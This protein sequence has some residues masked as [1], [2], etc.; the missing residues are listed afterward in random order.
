[1]IKKLLVFIGCCIFAFGAKAQLLDST[2]LAEAKLFTNLQ[3]ALKTPDEVYKLN[4]SKKKLR[5]LPAEIGKFTNLQEL[6]LSK[7]NLKVLPDEIGNLKNLQVLDVA[8]NKL[9]TF[10]STIG[11]LTNLKQLKA[12]KNNITSLPPEIGKLDSLR[13]MDLWDNDLAEFPKEIRNLEYLKIIDMRAIML[14]SEQQQAMQ[15]LVPNTKIN[16]DNSC[17]C[18]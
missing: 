8:S 2:K 18:R 9:V 11:K 1:M 14:N 17:H 3:E 12:G 6:N 15:D 10:P 4:L 13:Y 16:F 5:E 7:N